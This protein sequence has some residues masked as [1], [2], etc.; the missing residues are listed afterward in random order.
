VRHSLRVINTLR[1]SPAYVAISVTSLGIALGLATAAFALVDTITNPVVPYVNVDALYRVQSYGG[2]RRHL[3]TAEESLAALRR[4]GTVRAVTGAGYASWDIDADGLAFKGLAVRTM[5]NFFEVLGVRP[6]LGRVPVAW[7]SSEPVAIVSDALWK[8]RFGNRNAIAGAHLKIA[9]ADYTIAGVMPEGVREPVNMTDVWIPDVSEASFLTRNALIPIVMFKSGVSTDA[10]YVE[11]GRLADELSAT[12]RAS[13]APPYSFRLFSLRP[14]PLGLQAYQKAMM[15][16]VLVILL[17]GCL[18]VSALTLARG[19]IRRRDYALRVALGAS[20]GLLARE[21]L[22]EVAVIAVVGGIV[23]T[24]VTVWG[25]GAISRIVP[26]DFAAIGIVEPH[27]SART[28]AVAFAAAVLA[29]GVAGGVPA[30]LAA[31]VD[32]AEPLKENA[33]TTTGRS[34]STFRLLVIA[35]LALSVV[36]LVSASLIARA[37]SAVAHYDFGYDARGLSRITWQT[38][39]APGTHVNPGATSAQELVA[40][41]RTVPGV[42]DASTA[43]VAFSENQRATSDRTVEGGNALWLGDGYAN[44]GARLLAT[45]GIPLVAGRDFTESDRTAGGAVILDESAA[46]I[47]FPHDN[48]LDRTVKLGGTESSQAWLR[49]VG[50]A[51]NASLS[52]RSDPDLERQPSLYASLAQSEGTS[53]VF[54]TRPGAARV[55]VEVEQVVKAALPPRSVVTTGPWSQAQVNALRSREFLATV[56][57]ALGSLSLALAAIGLFSVL[58]YVVS[59]RMRELAIRV[60]LG[61]QRGDIARIVLRSSV[62]MAVGGAA[63][64]GLFG[65]WAA[66]GLRAYLYGVEPTDAGALAIAAGIVIAVTI[67]ASLPSVLRATRANPVDVLRAA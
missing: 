54:R 48:P 25:V 63:F 22:L 9:G 58:T 61:A 59:Q 42:L 26:D 1:R 35:E 16:S 21:V 19:M 57:A 36:V 15:A 37:T 38:R 18:N 44:G 64:G 5:P 51:R 32:P 62:E 55:V 39:G 47:L 31:R 46:K 66:S 53:I 52:F 6:R 34:E 17:I 56:F 28:F 43:T 23:G 20:R 33:G 7:P 50:V 10:A 4:F 60:A 2:D 67:V 13:D 49:V 41:V 11:L 3:P 65:M 27:W 45:L 8:R 30:W 29:V 40:R 14:N 24:A 12:H